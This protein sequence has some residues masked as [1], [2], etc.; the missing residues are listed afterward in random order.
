MRRR[1]WRA[2]EA[3]GADLFEQPR[4]PGELAIPA[5]RGV[6]G[7]VIYFLDDKSELA[8]VWDIEFEPIDGGPQ[9][10]A[11]LTSIDHVA[12]TMSYQEMLTWVLFYVSIFRTTKSPMVDV[13]D[14]GGVVRSQA[15]EG[16]DKALRLTLNGAENDRTLAGRFLSESFGSSV[17]HIAFSTD[18]AI[19]TA[20]ALARL[21]FESLTMPDNYYD[22]LEAR[23]GLDP[24]L[25]DQLRALNILYDRDEHGEY[26]QLYSRTYGDGFFFEI[27]ER[28]N[29]Y[30][31]YGAANAPFRTAAQ[32]RSVPP[33]V[34]V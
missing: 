21:G 25:A 15:I 13:I 6:G 19:A 8:R 16:D 26:L 5:I 2:R 3:L 1:P 27:V 33:R 18:D 28:R 22:D 4:G 14:P 23:F 10:G 17:Q 30:Q 32:Q 11:G 20:S 24:A 9:S 29:G 7:G 31:G 34:A 12:Q